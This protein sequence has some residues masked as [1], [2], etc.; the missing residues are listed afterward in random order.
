LAVRKPLAVWEKEEVIQLF[1][2]GGVRG[3]T[4]QS[5]LPKSQTAAQQAQV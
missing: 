3:F 2:Y 4:D 5:L 1:E